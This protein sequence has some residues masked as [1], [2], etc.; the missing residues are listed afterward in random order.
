VTRS[1]KKGKRSGGK[2]R[3]H[4]EGCCGMYCPYLDRER[5]YCKFL[6]KSLEEIEGYHIAT[7]GPLEKPE[8]TPG[9][10]VPSEKKERCR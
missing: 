5:H 8:E 9:E 10:A 2:D 1:R 6:R 3:I 7:C 4:F